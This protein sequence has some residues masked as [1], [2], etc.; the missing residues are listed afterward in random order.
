MTFNANTE[1]EIYAD[2]LLVTF[3]VANLCA[4]IVPH[5][6]F[7]GL[8]ALNNWLEKF[9][10]EHVKNV[11]KLF[12]KTIIWNLIMNCIFTTLFGKSKEEHWSIKENFSCRKF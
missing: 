10:K 11:R 6:Y 9:N 1:K 8:E 3:G 2:M 7:T 5:P 4:K 12:C